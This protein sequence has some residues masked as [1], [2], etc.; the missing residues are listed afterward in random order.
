MSKRI[1]PK[2]KNQLLLLSFFNNL[3]SLYMIQNAFFLYKEHKDTDNEHIRL[4]LYTNL[5]ACVLCFFISILNY[6]LKSMKMLL[7]VSYLIL[8]GIV[9]LSNYLINVLSETGRIENISNSLLI[10]L[11]LLISGLWLTSGRHLI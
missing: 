1:N 2:S 4:L 6:F 10:S 5:G 3:A 11:I 8:T 7:F 9:F